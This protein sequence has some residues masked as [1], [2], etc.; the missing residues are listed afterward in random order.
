[1]P[2]V[3]WALK[4]LGGCGPLLSYVNLM[5]SIIQWDNIP[6]KWAFP[7]KLNL[8]LDVLKTLDRSTSTPKVLSGLTAQ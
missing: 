5:A 6:V 8:W 3:E 2:R 7:F 1:M 4:A